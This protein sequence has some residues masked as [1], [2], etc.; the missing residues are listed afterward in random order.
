MEELTSSLQLVRIDETPC[1]VLLV[2]G[3]D[4]TGEAVEAHREVLS[5]S[6]WYFKMIFDEAN[7][8]TEDDEPMVF[9]VPDVSTDC[10][11]SIVAFTYTE[12]FEETHGN[13]LEL[14]AGAAFLQMPLLIASCKECIVACLSSDNWILLWRFSNNHFTDLAESVKRY[15][16]DNFDE[17]VYE[18]QLYDLEFD[19]L[20]ELVSYD[21]LV[22]CEK[23]TCSDAFYRWIGHK[24]DQR[25]SYAL[26]Q[27]NK[28]PANVALPMED[29]IY[30]LTR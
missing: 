17:L 11:K 14:L 21:P 5:K 27:M 22:G 28:I 2:S 10:I 30:R 16:R 13:V 26:L 20:V 1:D 9:Y 15:V 6:S 12:N 25:L 7:F 4:K 23:K 18:K 24:L 3:F 8:G 19:E 29:A